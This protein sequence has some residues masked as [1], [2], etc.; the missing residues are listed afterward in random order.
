MQDQ[1]HAGYERIVFDS[2][3]NWLYIHNFK[4]PIDLNSLPSMKWNPETIA[5]PTIYDSSERSVVVVV[6]DVFFF[7]ERG[8]GGGGARGRGGIFRSPVVSRQEPLVTTFRDL[9]I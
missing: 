9:C 2:S 3:N 5:V 8:G 7:L 4:Q 1:V 6:V